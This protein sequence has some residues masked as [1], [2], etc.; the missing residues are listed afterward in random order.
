[1]PGLIQR[2]RVDGEVAPQQLGGQVA[3]QRH[4]VVLHAEDDGPPVAALLVECEGRAACAR[5][6][7][8]RLNRVGGGPV[9]VAG[10]LAAQQIAGRA[11]DQQRAGREGRQLQAAQHAAQ[12]SAGRLDKAPEQVLG[13]VALGA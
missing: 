8:G 10:N 13:F 5:R 11:A 3:G 1:M 7:V 4:E 6:P 9:V 12:H 2:Q